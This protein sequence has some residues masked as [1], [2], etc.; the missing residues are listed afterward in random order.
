MAD[1]DW[2]CDDVFSGKLKVERLYEDDL[3]LAFL[4]PRPVTPIHAVVVPKAHI[5]SVLSQDAL[6]PELLMSILRAFQFVPKELGLDKTGFSVG[7]NTAAPGVTPHMHWHMN[8][9]GVE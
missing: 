4:H 6:D 5:D 2:Y 3:V 1:Y 8:G 9:P 7:A